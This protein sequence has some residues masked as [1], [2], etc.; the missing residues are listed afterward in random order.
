M[1]SLLLS[2]VA[3]IAFVTSPSVPVAH[4]ASP[5]PVVFGT[6]WDG[7]GHELQ[8]IVD[9]YLGVPGAINVQTDFVGAHAGDLDPW[10]WVGASFPTLLITEVAGN[11][12]TNELGWYRETFAR[13]VIDGVDDGIVFTGTETD[14]AS[15]LVTFPSGTTKF[16]FY[17]AT[18]IRITTPSGLQDQVFFTNRFHDDLGP[19]GSGAIHVPFDGDVQA[20][21]F[22]VSTWKGPNTWLVCF[23]DLD[24]GLPIQPCC[25]G[26]D[27]D[28]N[29]VVFQVAAFGA[30][31]TQS[32]SFGAMKAKYR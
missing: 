23:E 4:A 20:L 14:G 30:T 17:L 24:S 7:P 8:G 26:T 1:R 5:V 31:P 22:D 12:N 19:S 9:A 15:A 16:G 10:F 28:F 2:A 6:T 21:V 29:D 11:A 25:S 32:L 27:N 13:P 3:V 18:H